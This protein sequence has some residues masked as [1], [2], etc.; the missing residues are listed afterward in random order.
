VDGQRVSYNLDALS[1]GRA[2]WQAHV[3]KQIDA[4]ELLRS[5][6]GPP[7]PS[8]RESKLLRRRRRAMAEEHGSGPP[9]PRLPTRE[10]IEAAEAYWAEQ[11]RL[12]E[13]RERDQEQRR[14]A[15]PVDDGPPICGLPWLRAQRNGSPLYAP[16]QPDVFTSYYRDYRHPAESL[17]EAEAALRRIRGR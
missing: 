6:A 10:E 7:S 11:D 14:R 15:A 3:R 16:E 13:E 12:A 5:P 17:A 8:G 9:L 2:R 1:R 4:G